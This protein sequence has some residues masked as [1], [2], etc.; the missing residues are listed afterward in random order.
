MKSWSVPPAVFSQNLLHAKNPPRLMKDRHPQ[1]R[2]A[3]LCSKKYWV[4]KMSR[5]R[6]EYFRAVA[7]HEDV[8]MTITGPGFPGWDN[9]KSVAHNL[10]EYGD[11]DVAWAYNP[12][13][14]IG[15]EDLLCLKTVS[16][17]ESWWE[18]DLAALICK[19]RGVGL[20]IC[21]HGNDV[22]RFTKFGLRTVHIPHCANP[23]VF[24]G[25]VPLAE[26]K[27]DCLLTGVFSPQVYP[28]RSKYLEAIQNYGLKS[29]IR[30]HPGYRMT[31]ESACD[32][33]YQDYANALR[34][35][36]ISL[37]CTSKHKYSLAKIIESAMAGCIVVVDTPDDEIFQQ[38]L[39]PHC[40][41]VHPELDA[42]DLAENLISRI[43]QSKSGW[44]ELH[45]QQENLR[46]AALA[47]F[48]TDHYAMRFV[49]ACRDAI[50]NKDS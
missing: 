26:R 35:A 32:A 38:Y 11:F 30:P 49:Q 43:P 28:L 46:L 8:Q 13:D 20:V 48:T 21:H 31:S 24:Y 6:F 12:Q 37:C 47:R 2:I 27:T 50:S 39:A 19:H 1:L 15:F 4:S 5:C 33:Q 14:M 34:E 16:F 41:I 42:K 23:D 9:T 44:E 45:G 29:E 40:W 36:K 17:N 3:A 10:A 7:A 22:P 18:K 25:G